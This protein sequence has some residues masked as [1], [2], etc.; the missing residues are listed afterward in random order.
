MSIIPTNTFG[1]LKN[2]YISGSTPSLNSITNEFDVLRAVYEDGTNPAIRI[3]M[4]NISSSTLTVSSITATNAVIT[5][6]SATTYVSG[7][8][9]LEDIIVSL[10]PPAVPGGNNSQVQYNANGIFSGD[11]RFIFSG[12]N[13]HLDGEAN[14]QSISASTLT[15]TSLYSTSL[16]A[17][18]ERIITTSGSSILQNYMQTDSRWITNTT[19]ISG[20]ISPS[21]WLYNSYT[22]TTIGAVEGQMYQCCNYL[23]V[24]NNSVFFR[25]KNANPNIAVFNAYGSASTNSDIIICSASTAFT[26]M[27]PPANSLALGQC[28]VKNIGAGAITLSAT[29]STIDGNTSLVVPQWGAPNIFSYLNNYLIF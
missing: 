18:T 1:L 29:T 28:V 16:N 26:L 20:L 17:A 21:N 4:P 23:Y 15:A 2:V 5:N 13:L 10:S 24:Y 9:P 6:L 8:T 3:F 25:Y 27:L 22:G 19:L 12:G 11:S 14:V 7:G